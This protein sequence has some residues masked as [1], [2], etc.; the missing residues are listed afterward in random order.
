MGGRGVDVE[1]HLSGPEKEAP[2]P[3]LGRVEVDTFHAVGR[4]RDAEGA[5]RADGDGI[6]FRQVNAADG[7]RI[8][9]RPPRQ[10]LHRAL[11]HDAVR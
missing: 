10:I 8:D 11:Q 6:E 9:E 1:L 4:Q 7:A 2:Y 5:I 3:T